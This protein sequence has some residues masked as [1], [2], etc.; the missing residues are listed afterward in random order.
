[1]LRTEATGHHDA[2]CV[3]LTNL[4]VNVEVDGERLAPRVEG[5]RLV[6]V[7]AIAV[8]RVLVRT[9]LAATYALLEA[10][11]TLLEAVTQGQLDVCGC[12]DQ[13]D[14]AADAFS[15]FLHGL[16]R[17]PSGARLLGK[18]RRHVEESGVSS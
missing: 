10:R 15:L 9:S 5:G 12:A 18:L 6:V 14:A 1:M 13:L 16:I 2:L 17:A 8:P 4:A 3:A 11:Y 7:S